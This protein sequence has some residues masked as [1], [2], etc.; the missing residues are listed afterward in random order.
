MSSVSPNLKIFESISFISESLSGLI[1]GLIIV[2][3]KRVIK[4]IVILNGL[5]IVSVTGITPILS[6]NEWLGEDTNR[7]ADEE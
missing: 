5:K 4:A 2:M 1:K 3:I 6:I 7:A